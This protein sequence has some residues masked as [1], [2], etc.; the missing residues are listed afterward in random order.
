MTT[1]ANYIKDFKSKINIDNVFRAINHIKYSVSDD[2][3][4]DANISQ[5]DFYIAANQITARN[6]KEYFDKSIGSK[7][8]VAV[9]GGFYDTT[10]ND[11]L[12]A[13]VNDILASSL[14]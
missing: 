6:I 3:L 4:R 5:E 11:V 13:E 1:I 14:F 2:A 9:V 8:T 7:C 12:Y 10:I